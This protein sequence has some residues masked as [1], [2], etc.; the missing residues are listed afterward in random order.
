MATTS[1]PFLVSIDI[2]PSNKSDVN[3]INLDKD[4]NIN[5]AIVGGAFDALQVNPD[6]IKFGPIGASPI[7]NKVQDYNRDGYS[8]LILTFILSETGIDDCN[9]NSATL[10]GQ[11]FTDPVINV[12]GSDSFTV[13]PCSP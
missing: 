9:I 3:V 10:T 1:T 11:T 7:R 8:D 12:A 2:K 6:T 13:E 4:N 5:V